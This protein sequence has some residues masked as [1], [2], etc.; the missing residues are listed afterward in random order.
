MKG[1]RA[2]LQPST[3]QLFLWLRSHQKLQNH[4]LGAIASVEAAL[5][6]LH[7]QAS[8]LFGRW[9]RVGPSPCFKGRLSPTRVSSTLEDLAVVADWHLTVTSD[10]VLA[11]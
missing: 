10:H 2:T 3:A 7:S 6:F 9:L 4:R 1:K 5:G 8:H 11:D